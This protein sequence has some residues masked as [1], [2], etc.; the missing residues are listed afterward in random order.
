MPSAI[1]ESHILCDNSSQQLETDKSATALCSSCV[2]KPFFLGLRRLSSVFRIKVTYFFFATLC[3]TGLVIMA[4]LS[5]AKHLLY[6]QSLLNIV[7]SGCKPVSLIL[8]V[9]VQPTR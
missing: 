2:L 8:G 5:Y 1:A 3:I 7:G 9:R 4:D 6:M